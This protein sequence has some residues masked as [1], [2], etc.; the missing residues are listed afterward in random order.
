MKRRRGMFVWMHVVWKF[1]LFLVVTTAKQTSILYKKLL[2]DYKNPLLYIFSIVR[3]PNFIFPCVRLTDT[4]SVHLK[5]SKKL[6][7]LLWLVCFPLVLFLVL[8]FIFLRIITTI[9]IIFRYLFN[10]D[11]T[12]RAEK[13]CMSR[14]RSHDQKRGNVQSRRW[15][16]W[17][18]GS[19]TDK[20][21]LC[22]ARNQLLY[23]Y[24]YIFFWK[25]QNPESLIVPLNKYLT[26]SIIIIIVLYTV[27]QNIFIVPRY[28]LAVRSFSCQRW[29]S[30]CCVHHI[31]FLRIWVVHF[32]HIVVWIINTQKP[33][34]CA[35]HSLIHSH[36]TAF[37]RLEASERAEV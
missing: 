26:V 31:Y 33:S 25:E 16:R 13:M 14:A 30:M 19:K 28:S 8:L 32:L 7:L 10:D 5:M 1:W 35:P 18:Q 20:G 12:S 22:T 9:I 36:S 3:I 27:L 2:Q 34:S 15:R 4:Y 11:E 23:D 6:F 21:K 24:M 37:F 17:W 29:T